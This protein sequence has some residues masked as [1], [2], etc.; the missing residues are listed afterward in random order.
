MKKISLFLMIFTATWLTSCDSNSKTVT[1]E[2]K[3]Q[4]ET[5][6]ALPIAETPLFSF[7]FVGC[8][9][10]NRL[11]TI[12]SVP[13]TANL[14]VLKRIFADLDSI[15]PQPELLFFLGDM[16]VAENTVS[17]LTT[18]L[19]AWVRLY[20]DSLKIGGIELVAVPGN[21]EMLSY[22]PVINGEIP[23]KG[24]TETWMKYMTPYMPSDRNT[25]TVDSLNN[26]ATFSFVRHNTAFVV[27]NTDTY[28]QVSPDSVGSQGLIAFDWIQ[29]KI[30]AYRTD[31]AVDH[32]FVLG[33]KPAYFDGKFHHGHSGFPDSDKLWS[34]LRKNNV[35]A[36]L[37]A[38]KHCYYRGQPHGDSTY[39]VVAGNGGSSFNGAQE[40]PEYFGYSVIHVYANQA[41]RFESIGFTPGTNYNDPIP[42]GNFSAVRDSTTLVMSANP[43]K[44][45]G[46]E[47]E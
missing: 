18:Q 2:N 47:C 45:F 41:P 37:S 36:M 19:D 16:V 29:Q 42:A 38:H 31:P 34:V 32:I 22:D 33:H 9:R 1:T 5:F 11:D 30:E 7:A 21:H 13:S 15:A 8:N 17:D 26:R 46:N 44:G 40:P 4:I 10:V 27:M 12:P 24:A 3:L 25:V 14:P 43:N 20:E 35:S 28:N 39:Q 23:L 6:A